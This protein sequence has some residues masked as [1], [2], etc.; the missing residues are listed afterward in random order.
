MTLSPTALW[1]IAGVLFMAAEAF[2]TPG[3]G[4]LFAGLGAIT[5]GAAVYFGWLA[6]DATTAQFIVFFAA[7]AVFAVLLWK[8]LQRFRLGKNGGYN[9]IVGETAYVGS[10][11]ISRDNGGEVTWSGTIMRAEMAPDAP[12]GRLEAGAAVV[13]TAVH[14]NKLVVKPK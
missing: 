7:A 1:L 2:G 12:P 3:I 8:P 13:I 5:T 10:S 14:G 4:M 11:G 9:N 6:E